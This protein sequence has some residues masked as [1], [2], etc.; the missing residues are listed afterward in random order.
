MY[1]CSKINRI[2]IMYTSQGPGT[3]AGEKRKI[4]DSE[5]CKA[6]CEEANRRGISIEMLLKSREKIESVVINT[7]VP[8]PRPESKGQQ[9]KKPAEEGKTEEVPATA[10]SS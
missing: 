7:I 5:E 10:Q 6:V 3:Y 4:L 2:T 9:E 8:F 1:D